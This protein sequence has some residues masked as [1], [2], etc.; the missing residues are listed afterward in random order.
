MRRTKAKF[1]LGTSINVASYEIDD[2]PELIKGLPSSLVDIEPVIP[3]EG[4]D[5][6]GPFSDI[7]VP[8]T[9]PP[10]SIMVFETQLE[11]IEA[12]L[13][14]FVVSDA[15]EVFSDLDFVDLNVVLH[16]AEGEELDATAGEISV[17]DIPG[18]GKLTYCGLEGWM[19][20]LRHIM[21]YN[22]LGHP[23]CENL[24]QGAWAFDY[25]SARLLRCAT[26]LP[27]Y[28]FHG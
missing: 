21:K 1:I 11:G 13:D 7:I 12:D 17:Y 26:V 25:V 16:R 3:V 27:A 10:G 8:E 9:F 19:H 2:D 14:A 5:Y 15:E 4:A 23:L 18:M 24:R 28:E 20:P 6:E 22:D